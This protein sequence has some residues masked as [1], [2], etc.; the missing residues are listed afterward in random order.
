MGKPSIS[1]ALISIVLISIVLLTTIT[2]TL[3]A[4][5]TL[6]PGIKREETVIL[7]VQISSVAN[8]DNFN[9]WVIGTQATL[10]GVNQVCFSVL[11]YTDYKDGITKPWIAESLPTYSS[12]YTMLTI[13]IRRGI[14]WSD[15]YPIYS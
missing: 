8:P 15:G 9:P 3:N 11:Y 14:Y 6:P 7:D 12:D 5:L 10:I 2:T 13:K 1:Y 4:Q